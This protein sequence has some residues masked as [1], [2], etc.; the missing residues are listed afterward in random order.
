MQPGKQPDKQHGDD[1]TDWYYHEPGQ[2][3]VGPLSADDMRQRYRDRRIARDTLAWHEGL[4]E[5]QPVE[6]LMEELGLSGVQPDASL[7]PPVPLRPAAA[8]AS[9]AGPMRAAAAPPPSNRVG[10]IIAAIV[11]GIVGLVVLAILAAI[12][13]PAYQGYVERSKAAQSGRATQP[14][15]PPAPTVQPRVY[16]FDAERMAQTDSLAREL[17]TAAMRE[18][19][20]AN[21]NTCPDTYEFEKMMVRYPRYQGSDEDGWF[22][23][24]PARPQSGQCGYEVRFYGLGPEVLDKT[25]QYDVNIAGEEV[26]IY[27]RNN[28][29]PAGYAPPRCAG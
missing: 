8:T 17:V 25:V 28:T 24:D 21:G 19:Y 4:R 23:I 3:R 7:P 11:V 29:I 16:R 1:M 15:Q 13:L 26:A 18:F 5:W 20:A 22:G 14:V 10:C 2:G 6:R 27:C 9:H 12:A